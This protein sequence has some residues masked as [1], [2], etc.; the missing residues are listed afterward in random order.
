MS[1]ESLSEK[2]H[3]VQGGPL[4]E[5]QRRAG[6]GALTRTAL[7]LTVSSLCAFGA[8]G[9]LF[10]M[11]LGCRP[12]HVGLLQTAVQV[13]LIGQVLGLYLL[14]RVGKVRLFARGDLLQLIPFG[15]LIGLAVL[16]GDLSA[17]VYPAL[18]CYAAVLAIRST[19]HAGWWPLLQDNTTEQ[20]RGRFF[21]RM[22]TRLRKQEIV[23]P[24]AI[25]AYLGKNPP[26][27]RFALPFGVGAAAVAL[28]VW[29][30]RAVP[31]TPLAVPTVTVWVRLRLAWRVRAVRRCLLFLFADA[32]FQSLL[33]PFWIVMLKQRGLPE[34]QIVW[35]PAL[36][37]AGHIGGLG[38]SGWM[39]DHYGGRS[40]LSITLPCKAALGLAW[41]FLPADPAWL[42]AWGGA[43]YL[44]WGFVFGAFFM[45]R[46]WVLMQAV[47]D[48]Y[49]ADSFTLTVLSLGIAG[50]IGSL[51]GGSI[52][53]HLTHDTPSVA[54]FDGRVLYLAGVQLAWI[55][56]WLVKLGLVG[57]AEQTSA[58]RLM[59]I[60]WHWLLHRPR[61]H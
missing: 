58:R 10:L 51:L 53:D 6:Q 44:L 15:L 23:V 7:A 16:A 14:P 4:S 13:S 46:T 37:A 11:S 29:F 41:L 40:V 55:S 56:I 33:I 2:P 48:V 60:L 20:G 3:T 1:Q 38:L 34:G 17:A 26:P 8:V 36:A 50:A 19:G 32:L 35:L 54:G 28:G 45:G 31:E 5:P 43:F 47:P 18:A 61:T 12:I 39:V 49:Q 59:A 25:G 27:I 9:T 21:A 24:L 22:R 57:H 42:L 30:I 52:F